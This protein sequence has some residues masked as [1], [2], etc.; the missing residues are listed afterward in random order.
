M[1]RT[2]NRSVVANHV[3]NG[4]NNTSVSTSAGMF[5][6][7]KFMPTTISVY[8]IVGAYIVDIYYNH[9]YVE[10][11][12]YK[13]KGDVPTITEGYRHATFA[14][15]SGLDY[16]MKASYKAQ[17]YKHLLIGINEYFKTWTSFNTLTVSDC[18]EKIVKE[19][20][21]ADY[22]KSLDKN[23]KSDVLRVVLTGTLREF[24]KVVIEE[25]LT[26]IIDNHEEEANIEALKERIID[27][28]I[29]E[30]E[31]LFHKF[32]ASHFPDS[33]ETVDKKFAERMRDEIKNLNAEKNELQMTVKAQAEEI[34]IRKD[35]LAKVVARYRKLENSY[36]RI[37]EEYKTSKEAIADLEAQIQ[38]A[39]NGRDVPFAMSMGSSA[40]LTN[41]SNNVNK[42]LAQSAMHVG[43]N[44]DGA[45]NAEDNAEESDVGDSDEEPSQE[46]MNK[47]IGSHTVKRSASEINASINSK[48]KPNISKQTPAANKTTSAKST[49]QHMLST[50]IKEEQK[51]V[52]IVDQKT[53]NKTD[54]KAEYKVEQKPTT[55]PATATKPAVA[56]KPAVKPAVKPTRTMVLEPASD[57]EE[58]EEDSEE[59][60]EKLTPII[61][62][63][64][65]PAPLV[66]VAN[67]SSVNNADD[68]V[69]KSPIAK[70]DI[71]RAS[72][73]LDDY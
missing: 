26:A 52:K 71:G 7:T 32:L 17:H 35:Q 45:D 49:A 21:P 12:K 64:V 6:R 58:S 50:P 8:Q 16:Q 39:E 66:S 53:E 68:N 9:L 5:D 47:L 19:F 70:A 54:H 60:P 44:A 36:K 13:S 2:R 46:E 34:E 25:F 3:S 51:T 38:E 23:Q 69:P 48:A 62:H 29:A 63:A 10:A 55:K 14:F 67:I 42:S 41:T 56:A 61:K 57:A 31:K 20:I 37:S 40:F 11:Q 22:I 73:L 72:K 33:N 43:G 27:I 59:E 30:R 24:T 15:L 28:F 65:K 18:I 1:N 4:A